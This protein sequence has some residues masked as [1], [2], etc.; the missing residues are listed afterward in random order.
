MEHQKT[1]HVVLIDYFKAYRVVDSIKSLRDQ[2]HPQTNIYI[3]V[4]DNSCSEENFKT[5]Q[6][7]SNHQVKVLRTQNNIGYIAAVNMAVNSEARP[8][9]FILLLNPDIIIEDPHTIS[10]IIKNFEDPKCYVVGPAQ[11][12]DDGSIPTI[13][14]GYPTIG[15]LVAKRTFLKHTS[16][17][18]KKVSEYLLSDFNPAKKQKVPWLQ[19]SCVFIRRSY[20]EQVKG[21]NP[22]YFLFMA[23]IEVCE[24][25][26]EHGGYVLYDPSHTALADGK[27][28]SEGGTMSVFTSP[29]LRRHIIDAYKYYSK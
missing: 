29:A 21:L 8:T 25:A 11:I 20:W 6:N 16:W 23:D 24:K 3:T 14:R 17:G 27:R 9:D 10:G 12:N 26:Y 4:I 15:A 19:S 18:N 22:K 7:L 5:L 2:S 1:I 28:C 13:A